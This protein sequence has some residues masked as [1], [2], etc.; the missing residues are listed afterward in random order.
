MLKMN[1]LKCDDI[2]HEYMYH[3]KCHRSNCREH[4]LRMRFPYVDSHGHLDELIYGNF[5]GRRYE[6][7]HNGFDFPTNY[8]GVVANFVFPQHFKHTSDVFNLSS[9]IYG[10]V[11]LHPKYSDMLDDNIKAIVHSLLKHP[12]IKAMREAN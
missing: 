4:H 9:N 10:T 11:G 6:F 8:K 5:Y 3:G 7:D 1:Q 12:K 2:F